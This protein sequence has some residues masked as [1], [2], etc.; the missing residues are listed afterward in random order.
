MSERYPEV[1]LAVARRITAHRIKLRL[2]IDG[3]DTELMVDNR[4]A[5]SIAGA[6][7]HA[8]ADSHEAEA[9]RDGQGY[10]TDRVVHNG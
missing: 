9:T 10:I 2:N 6:L 4:M 7:T 5:A 8:L 1:K 3:K